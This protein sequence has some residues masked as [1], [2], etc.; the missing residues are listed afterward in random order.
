MNINRAI[1]IAKEY[2]WF[3]RF[4]KNTIS[5]Y[6]SLE[7]FIDTFPEKLSP[8]SF[9]SD[10]FNFATSPEGYDYWIEIVRE[11]S[12]EYYDNSIKVFVR[13]AYDKIPVAKLINAAVDDKPRFISALK[14]TGICYDSIE[15]KDQ[16]LI[17]YK[18]LYKIKEEWM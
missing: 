10:A 15:W 11:F 18:T 14:D 9:I 6:G 12:K 7:K 13:D 4:E 8:S 5:Q 17:A 1:R 2:S 3:K 16:D